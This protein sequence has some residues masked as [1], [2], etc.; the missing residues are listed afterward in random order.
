M[1]SE[2][3][4]RRFQPPLSLLLFCRRPSLFLSLFLPNLAGN[5]TV[6]SFRKRK[7][8]KTVR[9]RKKTIWS[10]SIGPSASQGQPAGIPR[11]FRH[12]TY[13]DTR[14][15]KTRA[16]CSHDESREHPPEPPTARLTLAR[17]PTSTPTSLHSSTAP[18]TNYCRT[19]D[20][21]RSKT[22]TNQPI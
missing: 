1:K 21:R 22:A 11:G 17:F 3:R 19:H 15:R 9:R 13:N 16:R 18:S 12:P 10:G 5:T 14:R 2:E 20:R 7:F 6:G 4:R 8:E